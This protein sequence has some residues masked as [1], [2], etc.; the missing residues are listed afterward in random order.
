MSTIKLAPSIL[1]ADF[2]ALG[3]AVKEAEASGADLIH[4]DVMDG[5]FV[6]NISIG[7]PVVASLK[8][9]ATKP[10]DVHLM[11]VD[12]DRYLGAFANAGAD[13]LIVHAEATT[14]LHRTIQLIK[15][16]G[17]K[18]G[19]AVNPATPLVMLEDV[20]DD[21]DR[22]LVMTVNPGFGGQAFIP[23]SLEKVQRA[24]AMLNG[25]P[26]E[27]QVDGGVTA[28]NTAALVAA[29]ADVL[30]AGAAVFNAVEGV[31]ASMA[32]IR[33]ESERGALPPHPVV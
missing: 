23:H 11:I 12:P 5:M 26:V 2:A 13:I 22:I 16:L 4:V 20:L 17:K 27:V 31:R 30:V 6:P 10:L 33:R 21:L 7:V 15:T 8:K 28:E 9:V 24:R 25:R 18:A 1:S 3:N 32:E 29:G 19:V 14:H